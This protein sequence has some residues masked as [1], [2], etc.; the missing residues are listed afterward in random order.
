MFSTDKPITNASEDKLGR[1]GFAERLA[2][3]IINFDTADSYAIALQGSW[4]CGKTSV[5]NMAIQK[6]EETTDKKTV[7]IKFNPWNF[8][9]TGQL[10][11]QFFATMSSKLKLS[12]GDERLQKVGGLIEKYSSVLEYTQY[13]P[14]VGPYLDVVKNLAKAAGKEIKETADKKLHDATIQKAKI[15]EALKE[16]DFQ[17]L[18]VIDDVDRLP[19]DQIRLIFQLVNSVAGFPHTVYL[20]SYDKDIVAHALDDVQGQRGAEYLEK[21][22]QVPFDMPP[23]DEFRVRTI[24]REK[25]EAIRKDTNSEQF[26]EMHW[27]RVFYNCISPLVN[28]L[29]DVN[30]LCN[31][32]PFSCEAVRGEVDFADMAG[33]TALR[34][35]APTVYEWIHNNG[36]HLTGEIVAKE[37]RDYE[38]RVQEESKKL[39]PKDPEFMLKAVAC[40]FPR[41]SVETLYVGGCPDE[42]QLHQ[43]MRIADRSKFNIYFSLSLENITIRRSDVDKSLLTMDEEQL[44]DY[45]AI[46]T[47]EGYMQSYLK[48]V[49]YHASRVPANRVPLL[50]SV[51]S[52]GQ[53]HIDKNEELLQANDMVLCSAAIRRLFLQIEDY[54]QRYKLIESIIRHTNEDSFAAITRFVDSVDR[55]CEELKLFPSCQLVSD[56]DRMHLCK[57]YI[58]DLMVV[59]G[60]RSL[61]ELEEGDLAEWIWKKTDEDTYRDYIKKSCTEDG[62]ALGFLVKFVRQYRNSDGSNALFDFEDEP[63]QDYLS[64]SDSIAV[65]NRMRKRRAFWELKRTDIESAA[66][67]SL[68]IGKSHREKVSINEVNSLL[69]EWENEYNVR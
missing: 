57:V 49:E 67:F 44:R 54:D 53:G 11:D 22:I 30:R 39:Y 36:E 8:T 16:I 64:E 42:E 66:A 17:I 50:I 68:L 40:L 55:N 27:R 51:L 26:D 5:L 2:K 37:D 25:L 32:L 13:I 41:F 38:K 56:A 58:E 14:V 45:L 46:L 4:G 69:S 65:I 1:S 63:Y 62:F 12:E 23:I 35:F 19:N 52:F 6:I 48:E 47:K 33:I 20:L 7:I 10:I 9:T 3:A 60:K 24:L 18:V 59:L 61:L 28:T 43:S 31:V 15:E 34:V 21:I 29:R